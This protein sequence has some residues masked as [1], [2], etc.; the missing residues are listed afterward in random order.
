[1]REANVS[2][3]IARKHIEGMINI[4]WKKINGHCLNQLPMLQSFV[5]IA[6]NNARVA[7]WLYQYRDGFGVQDRGAWKN[8]VSLL[9]EPLMLY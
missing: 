7:H 5:N 1:M 4:T 2:E 3:E 9:V 6:T 8:I